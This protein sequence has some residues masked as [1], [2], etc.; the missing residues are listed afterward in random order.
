MYSLHFVILAV[1]WGGIKLLASFPLEFGAL[2]EMKRHLLE[3]MCSLKSSVEKFL[4][5]DTYQAIKYCLEKCSSDN[6]SLLM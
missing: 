5:A 2:D 1:S 6:C 3:Q 4:K